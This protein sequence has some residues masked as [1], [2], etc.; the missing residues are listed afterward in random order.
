MIPAQMVNAF[1]L[2]PPELASKA[3]DYFAYSFDF[4]PLAA[5]STATESI[6]IQA[7]SSYLMMAV[8]GTARDPAA[9]ATVFDPP[10]V[11]VQFDSSGSGR[12]LQNRAVDWDNIVG[13]AEL[14]YLLSFP[15]WLD[16]NSTLD[17][18]LS[19]LGAQAYDIRLTLHGFKLFDFDWSAGGVGYR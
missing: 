14:P 17:A 1:P 12:L 4:L 15:K 19:N 6:Q 8:S 11:T 2:L 10:A 7:D 9:V 3:K 13:S 16:A 18:Q 5:N